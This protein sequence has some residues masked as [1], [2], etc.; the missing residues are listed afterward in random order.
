MKLRKPGLA[1]GNM[2]GTGDFLFL[3]SISPLFRFE[4][5]L[6]FL[7]FSLLLVLLSSLAHN[8][9]CKKNLQTIPLAGG[10]SAIALILLSLELYL[11]TNVLAHINFFL[12][13][14][15]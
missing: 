4:L 1:P 5:F 13:S 7:N 2:I 3:V 9:L 15:E 14:V 6:V 12:L 10:I 11:E 8:F